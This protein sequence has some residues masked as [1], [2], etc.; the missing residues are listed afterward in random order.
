MNEVFLSQESSQ[1][2][3]Q[4]NSVYNTTGSN[5]IWVCFTFKLTLVWIRNFVFM[6]IGW[7]RMYTFYFWLFLDLIGL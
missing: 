1:G 6:V 3:A 7:I 5:D 2:S 4:C